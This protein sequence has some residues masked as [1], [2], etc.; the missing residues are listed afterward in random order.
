M[1]CASFKK[2][3]GHMNGVEE[4]IFKVVNAPIKRMKWEAAEA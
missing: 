3:G 4:R 1:N 2:Q